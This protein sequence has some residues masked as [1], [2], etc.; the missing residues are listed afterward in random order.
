MNRREH[1]RKRCMNRR[2]HK[3]NTMKGA[4]ADE[5]YVSRFVSNDVAQ[6]RVSALDSIDRQQCNPRQ[7][8]GSEMFYPDRLRTDAPISNSVWSIRFCDSLSSSFA[9]CDKTTA[10]FLSFPYVC[11]EPVL[12]KQ[13][14]LVQNDA[15]TSF[16]YL[17]CLL[18]Q[19]VLHGRRPAEEAAACICAEHAAEGPGRNIAQQT[20]T[21]S[22]W[23]G[24]IYGS[25][26]QM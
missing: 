11:P 2:E 24:G 23:V 26:L 15:K 5:T 19:L 8:T 9:R 25:N 17:V 16:A 13:W 18:A 20:A 6:M 22:T 10:F 1:R 14:R 7:A 3:T 4:P 21:M 12:V